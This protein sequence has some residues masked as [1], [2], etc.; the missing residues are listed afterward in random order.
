MFNSMT[1]VNAKGKNSKNVG[2]S[3]KNYEE[4]LA[5]EK[6]NMLKSNIEKVKAIYAVPGDWPVKSFFPFKFIY[7][8]LVSLTRYK[9]KRRESYPD[10]EDIAFKS[11]LQPFFVKSF[12]ME[13]LAEKKIKEFLISMFLVKE[14]PKVTVFMRFFGLTS[15]IE[16]KISEQR[17]YM[18]AYDSLNLG[19][20]GIDYAI[21]YYNG[22]THVPYLRVQELLKNVLTYRLDASS[23]KIL[24]HEMEKLKKKDPKGFNKE[25]IIEFDEFMLR[26]FSA[27]KSA[28][29]RKKS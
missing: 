22:I 8:T 20:R 24:T 12:G 6:E 11:S 4:F 13:T 15:D 28:I 14:N 25:G 16:Y 1:E 10:E 21:D 17:L 26:C 3:K 29:D 5:K 9:L 27:L 18:R 2:K 7:K 23:T 19:G